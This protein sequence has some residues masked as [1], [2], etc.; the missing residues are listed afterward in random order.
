MK[1]E[2]V[3]NKVWS[4]PQQKTLKMGW[5]KCKNDRA[6]PGLWE[7]RAPT[8]TW[9]WSDGSTSDMCND[10]KQKW[11]NMTC[12]HKSPSEWA[13][14]RGKKTGGVATQNMQNPQTQP[15][16]NA[17]KRTGADTAGNCGKMI[18]WLKQ[19]RIQRMGMLSGKTNQTQGGT[20]QN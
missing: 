7:L 12:G 2:Q 11:L 8:N 1:G 4:H 3:S 18:H 15:M 5:R 19:A 16:G 13:A 20:H 14:T 17:W 9:L 6:I 10:S